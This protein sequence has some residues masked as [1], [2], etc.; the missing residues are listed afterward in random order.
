MTFHDERKRRLR[1]CVWTWTGPVLVIL[2]GL[3]ALGLVRGSLALWIFG[4]SIVLIVLY[5][6]LT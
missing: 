3:L 2:G 4:V 1:T 5:G 6:V